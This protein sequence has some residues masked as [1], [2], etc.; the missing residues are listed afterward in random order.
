MSLI[1]ILPEHIANQIAAGEVIQRPASVVKELLENAIDA[2]AQHIQLHVKD[3]GKTLIQVIDDGS[4]M[5]D[6]DAASCFLR[7]ATSKLQSADDLFRLSTK[8][9][10]G[11]ALASISAIAHVTLKTKMAHSEVGLQLVVEGNQ[12]KS[13]EAIVCETGSSFAVKNL[14]YNVPARRNFLKSDSIEFGHIQ[15]EFERVALAHPE[16]HFSLH[17]NN[18]EIY[19]LPSGNLRMRVAAIFGKGSNERLV[20]IEEETNIV[21]IS[22][23]VGKP[24]SAKKTRGEQFLFVNQRFFKDSYFNHAISKA[25]EGMLSAK[26]FASYCIYL[27]V[28]PAKIDVNIHPTK[29][30]IKFEE[31]RFIYSILLSSV[32]QALGKYNIFPTLD[33]EQEAAFELPAEIRKSDPVEPQIRVN[34]NYNPFQSTRASSGSGSGSGNYTS[35]MRPADYPQHQP[36]DWANFYQIDETPRAAEATLL[37]SEESGN[38]NQYLIHENFLFCPTKSGLLVIN[39]RRARH[40]ILFDELMRKFVI[41][42]LDAQQLLFPIEKELE[43]AAALIWKDQ[44]KLWNQLGFVYQLEATAL[45]IEAVPTLLPADALDQCIDELTNKAHYQDLEGGDI[46]H[47]MVDLLS[48][49]AARFFQLK[50]QEE[51]AFFVDSLFQ[52]EQHAFSPSGK[53]IMHTLTFDELSKK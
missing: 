13:N 22:G 52:C 47:F 32:R 26:H 33:F 15:S 24:D 45:S 28:D 46:A 36:E 17:H 2:N 9:F 35:A 20:P 27:E 7:H 3:A 34:P 53:S 30:E 51:A 29:T 6:S 48:R 5:N 1:R 31:D 19:K 44:Q 40:R 18:I 21:K 49:N 10:R 39:I 41:Q 43:P 42:A 12:L 16:L 23:F 38:S 11:E 8:G 4:G 37:E 50:H 14:F 25:F